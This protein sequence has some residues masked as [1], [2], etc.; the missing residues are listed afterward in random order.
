MEVRQPGG[1]VTR[2]SIRVGV[3]HPVQVAT[4]SLARGVVLT[5]DDLA[6]GT[7]LRWGPPGEMEGVEVGWELRRAVRVGEPI[8][9]P[10]AAPP[11][12]VT[13]G[14]PVEVV[15][16]EGPVHLTLSGEARSTGAR[17]D[18]VRVRL[19]SGR[20]VW[21]QVDGESRVTLAR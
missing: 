21:A 20:V 10:A 14:T 2:R 1:E 4:R 6:P 3:H 7:L 19:P 16:R 8:L 11:T 15:V 9:P 13:S 5:E 12:L 18:R 17:G